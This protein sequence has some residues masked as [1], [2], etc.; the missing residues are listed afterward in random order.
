MINNFT[1]AGAC[2]I[3]LIGIFGY[4]MFELKSK[5]LE[6]M[7]AV[8]LSAERLCAGYWV[9]FSSTNNAQD[10]INMASSCKESGHN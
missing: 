1:Q 10:P 5:Q 9:G 8:G 4:K 7:H 6:A 2:V 3:N